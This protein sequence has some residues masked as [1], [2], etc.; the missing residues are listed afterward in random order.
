MAASGSDIYIVGFD[1]QQPVYWKNGI[2][3]TL[4]TKYTTNA[5]S[6]AVYSVAIT[7]K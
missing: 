5:Q 6:G 1:G 3:S 2:E 4:V 7:N